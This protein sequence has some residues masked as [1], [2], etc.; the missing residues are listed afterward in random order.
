[1]RVALVAGDPTILN[2]ALDAIADNVQTLYTAGA[3]KFL[4]LNVANIGRISSVLI[5]EACFRVQHGTGY[6]YR[7]TVSWRKTQKSRCL[8]F[9]RRSRS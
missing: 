9:F 7:R 8:M 6:D 5:L 3:R 2:N 4:S 1:M